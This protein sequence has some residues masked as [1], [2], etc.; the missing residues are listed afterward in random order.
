MYRRRYIIGT[1]HNKNTMKTV[2]MTVAAI[3]YDLLLHSVTVLS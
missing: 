1:Y 3:V 2:L